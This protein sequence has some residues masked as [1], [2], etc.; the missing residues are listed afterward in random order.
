MLKIIIYMY[1]IIFN[2]M[3]VYL[4]MYY[5]EHVY[6]YIP[7]VYYIVRT[8]DAEI[9]LPL[10]RLPDSSV[11]FLIR[12]WLES[13][14]AS[15]QNLSRLPINRPAYYCLAVSWPS[16]IIPLLPDGDFSISG[17]PN[18]CKDLVVYLVKRPTLA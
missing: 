13:G 10:K 18:F 12:S 3:Y 2:V 11:S 14:R 8:T 5:Y 7:I 16:M 9:Q 1:I 17:R 6:T 4:Y 15:G